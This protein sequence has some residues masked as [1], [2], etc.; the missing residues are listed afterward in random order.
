MKDTAEIA[1][2]RTMLKNVNVAYSAL[3]RSKGDEEKPAMLEGL[4][5]Q[6]LALMSRIAEQRRRQSG[7]VMD[8]APSAA[9][10]SS[11]LRAGALQGLLATARAVTGLVQRWAGWPAGG[12]RETG[13][14]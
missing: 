12:A 8:S 5:G 7:A 4:K 3:L 9:F 11:Q 10:L 2:L 14:A 1:A 13:V 6:R